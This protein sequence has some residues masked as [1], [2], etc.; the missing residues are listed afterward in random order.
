MNTCPN[1]EQKIPFKKFLLL[2]NYSTITCKKCNAKL[3]VKNRIQFS[4]I[5][6]LFGGAS[7]ASITG[8]AFIGEHFFNRLFAGTLTGLLF[9][10]IL[11][12]FAYYIS[13]KTIKFNIIH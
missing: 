6:G 5:G 12:P 9:A 2:T 4:L 8:F 1:C 13:C 3:E 11:C 7:A 10:M